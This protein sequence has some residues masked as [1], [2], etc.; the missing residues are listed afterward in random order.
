MNFHREQRGRPG[1]EKH[2]MGQTILCLL[3]GLK[4][5][6]EEMACSPV[7]F[8]HGF[9]AINLMSFTNGSISFVCA[10]FKNAKPPIIPK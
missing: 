9:L 1:A 6:I 4:I 7:Y 8:N 5:K 3:S 2:A 10:A